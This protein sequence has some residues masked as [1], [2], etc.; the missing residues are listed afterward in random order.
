MRPDGNQYLYQINE[1]VNFRQYKPSQSLSAYIKCY[2]ILQSDCFPGPPER[3]L[4]DGCAE[5]IFHFGDHYRRISG[6]TYVEQPKTVLVG[7]I[8][9]AIELQA[10]GMT[11]MLGVRFQ[12]WGLYPF[13]G[14]AGDALTDQHLDP[15]QFFRAIDDL[16]DQFHLLQ[17]SDSQMVS[18]VEAFLIDTFRKQKQKAFYEADRFAAI[19]PDILRNQSGMSVSSMAAMANMSERQFNRKFGEVIGLSPKHFMRIARLQQFIGAYQGNAH[20]TLSDLIYDCGYYDP[21][22]FSRD[23]KN[24]AGV[25]PSLYFEGM[26]D[27]SRAMLL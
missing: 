17:L 11:A 25:S 4:P 16:S 1:G 19:I 27:L 15:T 14:I 21:A 2:W 3:I 23:F 9:Q 22:H 20:T 5:I 12:P 8:R 26:Q 6:D 7:Q 13:T 18:R 10:T 24:I